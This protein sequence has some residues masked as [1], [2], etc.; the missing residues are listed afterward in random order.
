MINHLTLFGGFGLFFARS[1]V[2]ERAN[3]ERRPSTASCH[4]LSRSGANEGTVIR[5]NDR[6][7]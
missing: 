3:G 7:K 6:V 4:L 2:E 1:V 5:R